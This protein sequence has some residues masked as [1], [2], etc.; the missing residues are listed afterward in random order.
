M[1]GVKFNFGWIKM[2]ARF[3]GTCIKCGRHIFGYQTSPTMPIDDIGWRRRG[4]THGLNSVAWHTACDS[5]PDNMEVIRDLREKQG[6]KKTHYHPAP[7]IA[8][9][10]Y[11]PPVPSV[12]I[13]EETESITE[14][15]SDMNEE[16][17]QAMIASAVASA[18]ASISGKP[19]SSPVSAVTAKPVTVKAVS[20]SSKW[21]A[22]LDAAINC[23]MTRILLI[24]PPGTGKSTTADRDGLRVTCH[25]DAGPESMIGTFIQKD[26]N[27]VWIDGPSITA[28]K[29]GSRIVADEID[30]T[31]PEC[32]SLLYALVDDSPSI[33]LP[34][35]EYVKASTGYQTIFTSNANP[36]DLPDAIL[37]RIECVILADVPHEKAVENVR[38]NSGSESEKLVSLMNNYYRGLSKDGFKWS[39]KP[40]LRRVRNFGKL[41]SNGM[42]KDVAAELI[43]GGASKEVLSA[44][45]T[46]GVR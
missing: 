21:W 7:Y 18:V 46:A 2:R 38:V 44:L 24:G 9:T 15:T 22:K 45:T 25:E 23:G 43:F 42:S 12:P 8:P 33:M 10:P 16:R 27:T 17:M 36:S 35:G 30:H 20:T 13:P 1:F 28:M 37:D 34:T 32:I 4:E 39:G 31:S 6:D 41:I 40:T 14:N 26:G 11:I 3:D 5:M 19:V 29:K